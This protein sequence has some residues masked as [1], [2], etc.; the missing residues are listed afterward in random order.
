M[1]DTLRKDIL[2]YVTE[3]RY[4]HILGTEEECVRL[5]DIFSF[6]DSEKEELAVAALLHDITKRFT[7]DEHVKYM[8]GIGKP[9]PKENLT[10]EKTLHALTGAYFAREKYPELV[11]DRIFSAIYYH[12]TGKG[13]MSLFEKLLYLADYIEPTRTFYDCVKIR[14]RFYNAIKNAKNENEKINV[15]NDTL[16]F[17]LDLTIDDLKKQGCSIH[18]D[19]IEAREYLISNSA[20]TNASENK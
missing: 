13:N 6:S 20:G 1:R 15:L 19:T 5:A 3:K 12:T 16:L 9:I 8:E 18:S 11:N 4:P 7:T 2:L 17:S 10:F 14:E